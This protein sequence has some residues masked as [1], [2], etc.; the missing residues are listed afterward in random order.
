MRKCAGN[1]AEDNF[2]SDERAK[3]K[4]PDTEQ[5]FAYGCL[6]VAVYPVILLMLLVTIIGWLLAL[7]NIYDRYG[8]YYPPD[9][10]VFVLTAC[11]GT[12]IYFHWKYLKRYIVLRNRTRGI[13]HEQRRTANLVEWDVSRL[14]VPEGEIDTVTL[15]DEDLHQRGKRKS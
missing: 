12:V 9:F 4:A 2:M 13:Q 15:P 8:I 11:V 7:L 6:L 3:K 10:T 1:S 5:L 14:S